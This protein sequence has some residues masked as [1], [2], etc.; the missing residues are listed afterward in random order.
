[1][2]NKKK[3]IIVFTLLLGGALMKT[4]AQSFKYPFQNPKLDVEER[5]K[6]LVSRMRKYLK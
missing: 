1:M 6:D 3:I 4:F 5:V 2:I